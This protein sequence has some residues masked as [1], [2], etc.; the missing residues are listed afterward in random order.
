[1]EIYMRYEKSLTKSAQD[2]ITYLEKRIRDKSWGTT[3]FWYR[4]ME[5]NE[6]WNGSE[7]EL[8]EDFFQ[9]R[10]DPDCDN[11]LGFQMRRYIQVNAEKIFGDN[12]DLN[13]CSKLKEYD[14][15]IGYSWE[16]ELVQSVAKRLAG[17][18]GTG[19]G[20]LGKVK[21]SWLRY[22]SNEKNNHPVRYREQIFAIAFTLKMSVENTIPLF[23]AAGFDSYDMR[24]PQD[25]IFYY[26]QKKSEKVVWNQDGYSWY[27]ALIL[28]GKYVKEIQ[29]IQNRK[30]VD[31]SYSFNGT[32]LLKSGMDDLI[33]ST[34]PRGT[35]EKELFD[36]MSEN[37]NEFYHFT[38]RNKQTAIEDKHLSVET[39]K[40]K[41]KNLNEDKIRKIEEKK[42]KEIL[43]KEIWQ[44]KIEKKGSSPN[45]ITR[46]N[47]LITYLQAYY[48]CGKEFQYTQIEDLTKNVNIKVINGLF[49]C[50]GEIIKYSP[51]TKTE[52]RKIN[53][54]KKRIVEGSITRD[55]TLILVFLLLLA[56][57][58]KSQDIRIRRSVRTLINQHEKLQV[59][60]VSKFS[61]RL[62]MIVN[63]D[64]FRHSEMGKKDTPLSKEER[65][66]IQNQGL[67]DAVLSDV[68]NL[69]TRVF[70]FDEVYCPNK[71][72]RSIVAY[73][74][75]SR[76]NYFRNAFSLK[77]L[78]DVLAR[79]IYSKGE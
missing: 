49:Q 58:T 45:R 74:M 56:Q 21:E 27:D 6:I 18:Y 16:N 52:K 47:Q 38:L 78:G 31:S 29:K 57:Y 48:S 73:L 67:R 39:E 53:K 1:M 70:G 43:Y 15:E 26:C 36:Y 35:I 55:D 12:N 79:I 2:S 44:I 37:Q 4:F 25:F 14:A 77:T 42:E 60:E 69:L 17:I 30:E 11:T 46:T 63:H 62:N 50:I 75:L 54:F 40:S 41:K 32:K 61:A 64:E 72:D 34:E 3:G 20:T 13:I 59:E 8:L 28:W 65:T 24:N 71:L 9:I 5:K 51:K 23:W 22:L 76:V 68:N 19:L 10:E 33:N 7:E 66:N